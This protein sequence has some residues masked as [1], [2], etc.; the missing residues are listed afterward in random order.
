[1]GFWPRVGT[2]GRPLPVDV[3]CLPGPDWDDFSLVSRRL[4][5]EE[6]WEITPQSNRMGYRLS[7]PRLV[8]LKS[9]ERD[10]LSHGVL[11]GVIQVPPDGQPI[12]LMSDAQTTGGY[13]KIGVVVSADLPLM[14]QVRPGARVR[15]VACDTP[16]A[17]QALRDAQAYDAQ[18]A[19]V[20][21]SRLAQV[22]A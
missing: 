4:L 21:A 5:A 17:L 9:R 1:M 10:L 8:R 15:F 13:P 6:A 12:V 22:Q 16:V 19:D 2:D 11:P 18:I 3:R 7:G 20:I 14:A